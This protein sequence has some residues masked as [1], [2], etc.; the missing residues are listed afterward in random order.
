MTKEEAKSF[1]SNIKVYVNGKS[2]EIQEKLFECGLTWYGTFS[3]VGVRHEDKPF[4]RTTKTGF[5]VWCSSMTGFSE[6]SCREVTAEEIL[7]IKIEEF[8]DGDFVFG[9]ACRRVAIYHSTHESGGIL[10]HACTD[11]IRDCLIRIPAGRGI[12]YTRDYKPATPEQRQ[13]LINEL[14]K[15]GKRWNADKKCIEDL[16]AELKP[17]DKVLVR[18]SDEDMWECNIFSN[19]RECLYPFRCIGSYYKQCIPYEGNEYLLGT[20]NDPQ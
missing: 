6:L 17:F 20:S 11:N 13:L 5:I 4:I 18:D 12:G 8:K 9:G 10:Y 1:L 2:K 14:A 3:G 7:S 19:K 15:K 16:P